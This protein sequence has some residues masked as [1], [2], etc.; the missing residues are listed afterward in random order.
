MDKKSTEDLENILKSTHPSKI[1]DYFDNQDDELLDNSFP[2]GSYVKHI[3]KKNS[4]LMQKVFLDGNISEGYG[5][6]IMSGE[7]HTNKKDVILR[8]CFAGKL[9][10]DETQ[11]A[12]KLYGFSPLYARIKRDSLIMTLFNNRP[13]SID[14]FNNILIQNGFDSL[15][16]VGTL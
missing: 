5:Y 16:E 2:F 10:I 6:K 14:D 4:I 9:S 3:L 1:Q 15:A 11:K 7:K 13:E 8:I 12:L